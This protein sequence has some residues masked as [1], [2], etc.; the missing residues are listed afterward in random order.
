SCTINVAFKPTTVGQLNEFLSINDSD[1]SSP[2]TVA[3]SGLGTAL[4]VSGNLNFGNVPIGANSRSMP[5]TLTNLGTG[6][7]NITGITYS[8]PEFS[9]YVQSS[10]CGTSI[11]GLSSCQVFSIFTPNA[12]GAQSGSLNIFD[13]DPSS[14]STVSLKGIGLAL[15]LSPG[16]I[17]FGYTKVLTTHYPVTVTVTNVGPVTVNFSSIAIGGTNSGD[18]SIQTSTCAATLGPGTNCTLAITFTPQVV[19]FRSANISFTDDAFGSPQVV[20]LG[21]TGN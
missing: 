16:S 13:S 17:S 8:N 6:P 7:I 10:T 21:G 1:S 12:S 5:A 9:Q 2:Q 11:A 19:G 18:F 14:P 20:L 3:L 15:K 4:S